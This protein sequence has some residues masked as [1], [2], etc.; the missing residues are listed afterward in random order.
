MANCVAGNQVLPVPLISSINPNSLGEASDFGNSRLVRTVPFGSASTY[1]A[2][3]QVC[4]NLFREF[5]SATFFRRRSGWIQGSPHS[6]LTATTYCGLGLL[7]P[8]FIAYTA[9]TQI[10]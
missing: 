5:G 10:I 3:G 7:L 8:G 6:S 1:L 9:A 2:Q 4:S